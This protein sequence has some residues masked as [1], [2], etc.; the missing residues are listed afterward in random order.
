MGLVYIITP[1]IPNLILL[2]ARLV[3]KLKSVLFPE[4]LIPVILMNEISLSS[5]PNILPKSGFKV[6]FPSF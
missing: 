2:L 5:F 1:F 4:V 6:N 3:I